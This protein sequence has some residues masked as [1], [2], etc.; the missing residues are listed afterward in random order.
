MALTL[1]LLPIAAVIRRHH[2]VRLEL[3]PRQRGLRRMVHVVCASDVAFVTL[4]LII[5]SAAQ[6]H[7]AVERPAR[8]KITLLQI[9]GGDRA[10]GS[11]GRN[12]RN[13]AAVARTRLWGW[14]RLFDVIVMLATVG[15]T[16]FV[17]HWNVINF[18]LNY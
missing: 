4:F 13:L 7:I 15:F 2:H 14:S 16:W 6:S 12:L 18:S 5:L 8:F 3:T 10:V 1:L 11:L 17:V 9:L